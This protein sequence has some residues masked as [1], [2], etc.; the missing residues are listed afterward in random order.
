MGD[1]EGRVGI[2]VV[3]QH[4]AGQDSVFGQCVGIGGQYAW[5]VG[6]FAVLV[7]GIGPDGFAIGV[8]TAGG[9]TKG[10]VNAGR[11]CLQQHEVVVAPA[12]APSRVSSGRA[13]SGGFEVLGRVGAGHDGLL[14]FGNRRRV[15]SDG[16]VKGD[17]GVGI[18]G[19]PLGVAT[20]VEGAAI[21]QFQ[22]D[23]TGQACINL[24]PDEQAIAFNEHPTNPFLGYSDDLT[25]N[26]FDDGNNTA[27]W[28]S[29]GLPLR[30]LP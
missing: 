12:M 5:S 29:P 17:S 14:Q 6:G 13:R 3:A 9:E 30:R 21:L 15:L 25:N 27:H 24:V 10:R 2:A 18:G 22:R 23:S 7:A 8:R 28:D 20:Q 16:F 11:S 19:A 26:A 4:I 1:A